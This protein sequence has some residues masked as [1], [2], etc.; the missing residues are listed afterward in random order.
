MEVSIYVGI[1]AELRTIQKI[2]YPQMMKVGLRP[3]ERMGN[4]HSGYLL[5]ED[6]PLDITANAK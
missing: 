5:S 4:N 1:F 6:V 3:N 2:R